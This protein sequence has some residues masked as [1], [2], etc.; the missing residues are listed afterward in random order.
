[1]DLFSSIISIIML[2]TIYLFCFTPPVYQWV[3]R[4]IL[5]HESSRRGPCC[6]V[7]ASLC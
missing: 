2:K 3:E 1:M 6:A 7:Q 5:L 4:I